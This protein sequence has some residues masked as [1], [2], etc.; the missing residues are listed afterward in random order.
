MIAQ[1]EPNFQWLA[2]PD[3]EGGTGTIYSYGMEYGPTRFP[4]MS[5]VTE[6]RKLIEHAYDEGRKHELNK[7]QTHFDEYIRDRFWRRQ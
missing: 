1:P 7:L 2:D 4:N 3:G 5:M 6:I